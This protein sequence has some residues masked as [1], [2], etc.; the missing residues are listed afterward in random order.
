[1]IEVI[2]HSEYRNWLRDLKQQI[3]MLFQ[4]YPKLGELLNFEREHGK[5]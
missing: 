2:E 5:G 4:F 1:M 3:K